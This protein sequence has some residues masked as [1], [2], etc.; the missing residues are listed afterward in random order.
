MFRC[1]VPKIRHQSLNAR[2]SA[3]QAFGKARVQS[4]PFWMGITSSEYEALILGYKWIDLD[5]FCVGHQV[6]MLDGAFPS[7]SILRG[8][9]MDDDLH[10]SE[11][12]VN[13]S[14]PNHPSL[15]CS[16]ACWLVA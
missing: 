16:F 9:T 1:R 6:S 10:L 5:R 13:Q 2:R 11:M 15:V 8:M 7:F 12:G 4:R 3:A 14:W